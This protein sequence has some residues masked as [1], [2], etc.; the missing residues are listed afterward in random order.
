MHPRR[1]RK[2]GEPDVRYTEAAPES[3][4]T[5]SRPSHVLSF[6]LEHGEDKMLGEKCTPVARQVMRPG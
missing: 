5:T 4:V 2:G 6:E 3:R 1:T